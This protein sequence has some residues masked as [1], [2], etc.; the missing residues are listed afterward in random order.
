M[1]NV[2]KTE[3]RIWKIFVIWTKT[4]EIKRR[5]KKINKWVVMVCE[6]VKQT[7]KLQDTHSE[8]KNM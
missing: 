3:Q 7:N 5:G 8:H 1:E 6:A 2:P 4:E